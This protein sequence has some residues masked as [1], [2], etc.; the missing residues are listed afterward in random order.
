M[1]EEK[2]TQIN[3]IRNKNGEVATDNTELQRI[4]RDYYEQLNADKFDNL[5]EMKMKLLEKHSL[6]RLNQEEIEN[7]TD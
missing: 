5:E 3:K 4:K 7:I 6:S 1:R 2:E